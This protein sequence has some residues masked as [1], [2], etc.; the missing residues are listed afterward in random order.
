MTCPKCAAPIAEG[1]RLCPHC[2]ANFAVKKR[3]EKAP[4][5]APEKLMRRG[6]ALQSAWKPLVFGGIKIV[7]VLAV[8]GVAGYFGW[9]WWRQ[10][11]REWVVIVEQRLAVAPGETKL[12]KFESPLNGE[13]VLTVENR[14]GEAA[15][16]LIA[17][18]VSPE[19]AQSVAAEHRFL[20]H[21]S[22]TE[23][24]KGRFARGTYVWVVTNKGEKDGANVKVT[25]KGM[26]DLD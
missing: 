20:L 21:G 22:A 17:G 25:I 8:L 15:F 18:A 23:T 9:Q 10:R 13:Y 2:G 5:S 24:R 26:A 19:K 7:G 4:P 3:P 6:A 14:E 16:G 1:V 12:A 11:S